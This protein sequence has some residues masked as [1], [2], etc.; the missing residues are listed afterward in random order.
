MSS[1]VA[2]A[3]RTPGNRA[4]AR[5]MAPS[6]EP[7]TVLLVWIIGVIGHQLRVAW[8]FMV[9]FGHKYDSILP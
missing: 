2:V 6:L 7:L 5:N 9:F 1:E 8:S 4:V 3:Q